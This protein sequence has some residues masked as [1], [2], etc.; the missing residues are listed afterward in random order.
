[1]A[2]LKDKKYSFISRALEKDTFGVVEFKGEEGLSKIYRFEITLITDRLDI[3]LSSVVQHRGKFII[4][5]DGGDD[6]SFNGI[7][8]NFEQLQKINEY[9]FY[10]AI[11]VPKLWYLTLTHHNQVFLNKN[12]QEILKLVLEDAGLT[13]VDYEFRLQEEYKPLEY[14]CQYG[15]SHFDFI[16]RWCEREGIYYFFEQGDEKEKVI[17]TDT[18]ISHTENPK[19]KRVIYSP[20]SGLGAGHRNEIVQGF[21][22]RY[23]TLPKKV[24]L[25][26]YNYRKPSLEVVGSAE[27]DPKGI[28]DVYYYGDHFRTPQEGNRL[29]QIRAEEL[30]C[31]R[32]EFIG[33]STVP[34]LQ[35]GYIF[36]LENHYRKNFN[37]RYLTIELS[38]EGS[39]TGYLV[40][41]I[42]DDLSDREKQVFYRNNFTAIPANVQF[43]P[44]RMTKN[45]KIVG[46]LNARID[47]SG[48]GKYAEL[49]EEG[50]Y[51]VIL[52]FD[53]SGRKDGKASAW[54]RMLQP[55]AGNNH[56]M[57]FPLH[58]GTEVLLTFIDGNPDRP[59]IAGAVP[60]PETPSLVTAEN[61]TTC[62]ITTGGGNTIHMEDQEGKQRI[63]FHSPTANTSI[64]LGA[65]GNPFKDLENNVIKQYKAVEGVLKNSGGD[66]DDD[67]DKD[68]ED[69]WGKVLAERDG[70][71]IDTG[72]SLEMRVG[73][74][75]AEVVGG[76]DTSIVIGNSND[77]LLGGKVDIHVPEK[78]IY[79]K[80]KVESTVKEVK[81]KIK[82][83]TQI[84][85]NINMI[86]NKINIIQEKKEI[87]EKS[88][89]NIGT[90]T[91]IAKAKE[92]IVKEMYSM[93][94]VLSK[95]IKEEIKRV[96]TRFKQV[97][98]EINEIETEISDTKKKISKVEKNIFKFSDQIIDG[99][100]K[101]SEIGTYIQKTEKIDI[102]KAGNMIAQAGQII[103]KASS[104]IFLN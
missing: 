62:Q 71:K 28:G 47:A 84:Q 85:N 10:R 25:R 39:Q 21:I 57:H 80:S 19:G 9:V 53:I 33:D 8:S 74:V 49:D 63:L 50:R 5:R 54:I 104:S 43:R 36:E 102:N 94:D 13:E 42:Q 34:Y 79:E 56:G 100:K 6:V 96:E 81:L 70:L 44:K 55:Y 30:L 20:P 14:V 82:K 16:S 1:M 32:E 93:F 46:T 87:N 27:I 4:H 15:E 83:V 64:R 90:E 2:Y 18:F 72:A 78:W 65:S 12:V 66:G 73:G 98:Q 38:H 22:C 61:Q 59:V 40:S 41:G 37:Q 92:E 88:I 35:P 68:Y 45:P 48:S 103:A 99:G 76:S 101:I 69:V 3:D 75:K 17:F 23:N 58:K 52:P 60:N 89:S 31:R 29:A 95:K 26:D 67:K 7:I 91:K 24:L 51:K 77:V 86:Q 11:L 97:K